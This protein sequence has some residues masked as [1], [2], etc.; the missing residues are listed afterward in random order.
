[1][2]T[3]TWETWRNERWAKQKPQTAGAA[4]SKKCRKQAKKTQNNNAEE[5]RL[6]SKLYR[7]LKQEPDFKNLPWQSV[8]DFAVAEVRKYLKGRQK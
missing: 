2:S 8:W 7:K 4:P 3:V 1:M 6:A 5:M